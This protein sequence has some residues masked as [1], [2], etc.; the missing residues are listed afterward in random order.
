MDFPNEILFKILKNCNFI[1]SMLILNLN[2]KFRSILKFIIKKHKFEDLKVFTHPKCLSRCLMD[3]NFENYLVLKRDLYVEDVINMKKDD[4]FCNQMIKTCNFN[5]P[6]VYEVLKEMC[7]FSEYSKSLHSLLKSYPHNVKEYID[8]NSSKSF[9]DIPLLVSVYNGNYRAVKILI[10][11]NANVNIMDD[12]KVRPINMSIKNSFLSNNFFK[13]SKILLKNNAVFDDTSEFVKIIRRKDVKLF[14]LLMNFSVNLN[15]INNYDENGV[16]PF[17][18]ATFWENIYFFNKLI[19][20]GCDPNLKKD[21]IDHYPPLTMAIYRK[22]YNLAIKLINYKKINLNFIDKNGNTPLL[23]ATKSNSPIIVK[24]LLKKKYNIDVNIID[25]TGKTPLDI[26][27]KRDYSEI[28]ELFE[29][30][31]LCG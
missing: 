15:F 10:K 22:Q 4:L 27:S 5:R 19:N 14:N 16:T 23:S 18:Y 21:T 20:N 8:M 13:I 26:A 11:Y 1:S 17:Y 28:V 29:K 7:R 2:N 6:K 24:E 25:S 31:K 3:C 30:F 9:F 12:K